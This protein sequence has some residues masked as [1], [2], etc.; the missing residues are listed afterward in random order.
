LA[1]F[2]NQFFHG[3]ERPVNQPNLN[4]GP[5]LGI[6][7]DPFKN[8]KTVI[9]VGGGLYYE[10]AIWN[11]VLFDRPGR[12]KSGLFLAEAVPCFGGTATG[13]VPGV[14]GGN[15][16]TYC[17]EA[18]GSAMSQIAA[19]QAAYQAA[20]AAAGPSANPNFIGTTLQ[21]NNLNGIQMFSPDY[22]SPYSIQI[23]AG[24]QHQLGHGTVLSV[25]YVRNVGLHYLLGVD[26]NKVG[27]ARFLSVGNV[28]VRGS[29]QLP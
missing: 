2:D 21:G 20:I 4:F 18:V 22:R 5:Q 19:D 28:A 25:D 13:A 12:L 8:G 3:L 1:Q 14:N 15:S 24:V 10:N 23:N 27:D 16:V 26:T 9:R 29:T 17:G 6:A 11:N 7:W